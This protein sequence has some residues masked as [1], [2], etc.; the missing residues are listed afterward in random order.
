M[1][2]RI[3]ASIKVLKWVYICSSEFVGWAGVPGD[4]AIWGRTVTPFLEW[5]D[6]SWT[7]RAF[8]VLSGILVFSYQRWKPHAIAAWRK[9]SRGKV[10]TQEPTPTSLLPDLDLRILR[11][12]HDEKMAWGCRFTN[13]SV[14]FC[15]TDE[16]GGD[17]CDDRLVIL[18]G[19]GYISADLPKN[20]GSLSLGERVYRIYGLTE[21]G[22]KTL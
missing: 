14:W 19:D 3:V 8:L 22:R 13:R 4:I 16:E 5:L 7:A 10:K 2:K 1:P 9:V 17:Q 15:L 20:Y 12:I 18:I 6:S 21:K 11:F